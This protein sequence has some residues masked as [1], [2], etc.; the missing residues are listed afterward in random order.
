MGFLDRVGRF[1]DDV[2]LLPDEVR[3]SL[4]AG[5]AALEA[6]LYEEAES[7]FRDVL[8]ERP[9]L[10]RAALGLAHA[11]DGLGDREG[12]LEALREARELLPED[13]DLAVWTARLAL[14][15]GE[16]E[17]AAAAANDA[18]RARAENGGAPLAEACALAAWAEWRR[19]R[20]DRAARE[21]RKALS[22]DSSRVDLQVALVEALADARDAG[23]ARVTAS[24]LEASQLE[25]AL[26]AR[27]GRALLRT[28]SHLD[29]RPFLEIAA[30]TGEP[31]AQIALARDALGRGS[32]DE[33]ERLARETVA[34]GV[35][36]EALHVLAE[37]LVARD[38][39][40]EAAQAFAA[41]A[42][43]SGNVELHREA[44]RIAPREE[45]EVYVQALRDASP[46]DPVAAAVQA[47][48]N[49]E[50]AEGDEPRACL[51]RAK[52]SLDA[53]DPLGALQALDAFD[54]S[55]SKGDREEGRELRRNALR[56]QWTVDGE[57]DLATAIGAVERFATEH[58]ID[59]VARR[60]RALSE[61]LDR[62]LLLAVLGEFNAGKSTLINAFIGSDVAP[63]GIVPTTATLNV[64][65]SG[66]EKLVR[67]IK[68]NGSTREGSHEQLKSILKDIEALGVDA[69][70][71]ESVDRVEIILPSETLEKVW[72]LDAPGTNA[73][74]EEHERLAKEAARRAD[75]VL[76]VFDA[77][78]AGKLTETR[79]HE[80][81]RAQG[82][83]VVPVLN[84][85]DRLREGELDEV[86]RVV[87]QGFGEAPLNI[88][89]RS[90][91]KA[92]LAD[93]EDAYVAS[94][95]PALLESL[96]RA[97]FSKSRQ[98]KHA[99]CAGRLAAEL[100]AAL[101]TERKE[102]EAR[103]RRREAL[104]ARTESLLGARADAALAVDDALR[105]LEK[106]L[107]AA[108]ESAADEV[109][110]FVRPR[111][112]QFASHG[113]HPEDRAFLAQLLE[114]RL[115][116]S[117]EGCERRVIAR[118]RALLAE[119]DADADALEELDLQIGSRTRPALAA[120]WGFQRGVLAGGA[121]NHF[122]ESVLPRANLQREPL[123]AALAAARVSPRD[124]LRPALQE[125]IGELVQA[126]VGE[127]SE[128]IEALEREADRVTNTV[129]GPMRTLREVLGEAGGL[130]QS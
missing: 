58:G 60:A 33:A 124:E 23:G 14:E 81:L 90:A 71:G 67:V 82:R 52:A 118:L 2:L 15:I 72:I 89:A 85:V 3:E 56:A 13:G 84:K 31:S 29:A 25:A 35:G 19:G 83:R 93:D 20:P 108:F 105:A 77:A 62:P 34:K 99:A 129:F 48:V 121:L 17:T 30:Q 21:L 76:W 114:R 70:G 95:F 123:A 11:R 49:G 22:A 111:A 42:S 98:L 73:L 116:A 104:G 26:A 100:D 50:A 106:D 69:K 122:F 102:H 10:V 37:V 24:K 18:A 1:I 91:L 128:A 74:D 12:T 55:G 87:R 7:I 80:A 88:S 44:A 113:V 120:F 75:A 6:E 46:G 28:G 130:P 92:R 38:Q 39:L 107:D 112:H 109:L 16:H 41:A 53:G 64:L 97:V 40:A 36:A 47:W 127:A 43:M 51:A 8:A 32:L 101:A 4:Q 61:E 126:L 119:A 45:A 54:R 103:R 68:R 66:A 78:Q 79:I 117:L 125:A 86:E 96:E 5:D 27:V 65:R 94:G 57:L 63:M 9:Q 110:N 59:D 115:R